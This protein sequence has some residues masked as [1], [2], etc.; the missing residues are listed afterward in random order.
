MTGGYAFGF[1]LYY[2]I[3]R[4]PAFRCISLVFFATSCSSAG[5]G[6]DP[7]LTPYLGVQYM[8]IIMHFIEWNGDSWPARALH[9]ALERGWLHPNAGLATRGFIVPIAVCSI[10]S[11]VMLLPLVWSTLRTLYGADEADNGI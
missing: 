7:L 1:K 5:T 2:G 10:S 6:L 8:R 3:L 9:A 4:L 11:L